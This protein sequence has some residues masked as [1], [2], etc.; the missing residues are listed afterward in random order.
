V[1]LYRDAICSFSE[2]E[3]EGSRPTRNRTKM[4]ASA[5]MPGTDLRILVLEEDIVSFSLK[6]HRGL[7]RSWLNRPPFGFPHSIERNALIGTDP[8]LSQPMRN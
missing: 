6:I 8:E 4:A 3:A 1:N 2:P 7:L 5:T